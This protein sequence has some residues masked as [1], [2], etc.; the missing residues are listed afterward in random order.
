MRRGAGD[1]RRLIDGNDVVVLK[2]DLNGRVISK[3]WNALPGHS[4]HPSD[5]AN[6]KLGGVGGGAMTIQALK[7]MSKPP[8]LA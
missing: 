5:P 6:P 1:A 3:N 2:Q 8:C 7:I 4:S